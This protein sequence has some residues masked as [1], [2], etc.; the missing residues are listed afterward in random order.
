[1]LQLKLFSSLFYL[2]INIFLIFKGDFVTV[3]ECI[4]NFKLSRLT[5][6]KSIYM[7]AAGTGTFKS[8]HSFIP[9]FIPFCFCNRCFYSTIICYVLPYHTASY[10]VMPYHTMPYRTMSCHIMPYIN[11]VF[12]FVDWIMLSGKLIF[13]FSF[14]F[15]FIFIFFSFYFHLLFI[16]F[17]C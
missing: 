2:Q 15:H 9:S 5:A 3:S 14:Y 1:M 17:S 8:A 10:H 16:F 13:K 7:I 12:C 6:A 4:G 11:F